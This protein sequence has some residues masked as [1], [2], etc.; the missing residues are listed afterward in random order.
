MQTVSSQTINRS[1]SSAVEALDISQAN[2]PIDEMLNASIDWPFPEE[3]E[4]RGDHFV[5]ISSPHNASPLPMHMHMST[6]THKHVN[7]HTGE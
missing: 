5:S 1:S 7:M 2:M 4:E 6:H 3:R